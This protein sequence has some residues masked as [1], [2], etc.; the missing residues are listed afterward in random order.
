MFL[1]SPRIYDTAIYFGLP[2]RVI[3]RSEDQSPGRGGV[4]YDDPLLCRP[5][6][7]DN[8]RRSFSSIHCFGSILIKIVGI[9]AGGHILV[10][11]FISDPVLLIVNHFLDVAAGVPPGRQHTL[12][13]PNHGSERDETNECPRPPALETDNDAQR[14][15]HV[16]TKQPSPGQLHI[17]EIRQVSP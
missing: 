4:G 10:N 8:L 16:Q 5:G 9:S 15:Y 6:V 3:K 7:D 12:P 1:C 14:E 11:A 17:S 2:E 13:N